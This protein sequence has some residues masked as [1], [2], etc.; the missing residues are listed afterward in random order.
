MESSSKKSFTIVQKTL[1]WMVHTF[2]ASGI[3]VALLSII[4]ISDHEFK[5]A[6]VW[7]LAAF[8]I[9]G[10]DGTF[11]RMCN[12]KEVLPNFDGKA[13]DYVIDFSTYALIPAYFFYEGNIFPEG[14]EMIGVSMILLVSA[15]YYGRLG[16]V[17]EDL[18]FVGFPVLWNFVIF[19]LYFVYS[20]NPWMN[21]VIVTFLSILHFVPIKFLY[22]SR[23]VRYMWVN[24]GATV[25]IVLTGLAVLFFHEEDVF[26]NWW[27]TSLSTLFIA[28]FGGMSV[29][30]TYFYKEELEEK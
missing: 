30:N 27:L 22:P 21:L 1:A 28:Y 7:L 25:G 23:T 9:D 12:V 18:H 3:I 5:M 2:T 24:L 10:I 20:L 16:M 11:A 6:M 29:Y 4:A 19:Y 15:M 8:V 14:W 17:T 26:T 13:V